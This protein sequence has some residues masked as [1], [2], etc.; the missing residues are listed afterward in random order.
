M[1]RNPE[2]GYPIIIDEL[3]V[4]CR[5][6]PA[7][8]TCK[9]TAIRRFGRDEPPYVDVSMCLQ[10]WTCLEECPQGAIVRVKPQE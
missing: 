5:R 4:L 10:C 2:A 6:C 7:M 1:A 9:G 8:K 3:C